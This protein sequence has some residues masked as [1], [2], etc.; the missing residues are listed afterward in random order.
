MTSSIRTS[1]RVQ[2]RARE[3]ARDTG[4]KYTTALAAVRADRTAHVM[5]EVNAGDRVRVHPGARARVA[6]R[7]VARDEQHVVLVRQAGFRPAGELEYCILAVIDHTYNG[8]GPGLI[9]TS[10]NTLGGGWNIN[11]READAG[12]EILDVIA[13]GTYQLSPRRYL[14]VERIEVLATPRATSSGTSRIQDT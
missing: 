3:R 7:V 14:G 5:P 6:W 1:S 10:M 13:E 4:E 11:G 12:Q 8:V 2:K 9:R